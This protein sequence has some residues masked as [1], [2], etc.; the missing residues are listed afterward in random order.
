MPNTEQ[1][2][3]SFAVIHLSQTKWYAKWA[4]TKLG[5]AERGRFSDLKIICSEVLPRCLGPAPMPPGSLLQ[6]LE[7][8]IL[9]LD[10]A[11][12]TEDS[13]AKR[14]LQTSFFTLAGWVAWGGRFMLVD[15][16]GCL[17]AVAVQPLR[18]KVARPSKPC[19]QKQMSAP[20]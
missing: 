17:V 14:R 8:E 6:S 19:S 11:I 1:V 2:F 5:T 12:M 10:M 15:G 18:A 13:A 20:S 4:T 9:D 7:A 16:V 3:H